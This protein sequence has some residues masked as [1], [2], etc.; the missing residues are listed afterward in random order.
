MLD[1][2]SQSAAAAVNT[3]PIND[4]ERVVAT[5]MLAFSTDPMSRWSLPAPAVFL[6]HFPDLVHA[7]AGTA[8][9]DGTVYET[10]DYSGAAIWLGPGK[11]PNQAGLIDVLQKGMSPDRFEQGSGLFE[12]MDAFHPREPHWY[13]PLIGVD[14]VSQ[15]RG[16]GARLMD[17]ALRECDRTRLP[18]YLES[19]NPANVPFYEAFG[20]KVMGEIQSGTS[21]VMYPML[22]P[23]AK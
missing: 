23:A 18:A 13:L 8:F 5:I 4:R 1:E 19:S 7:F 14:P 17:H 15:G 22:R 6:A 20:F 2:A 12:Q 16:Y 3:V 11:E 9:D 10:A 21:P